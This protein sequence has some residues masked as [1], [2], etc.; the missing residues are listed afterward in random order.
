MVRG[1]IEGRVNAIFCVP[2]R[3]FLSFFCAIESRCETSEEKKSPLILLFSARSAQSVEWDRRLFPPFLFFLSFFPSFVSQEEEEE[4]RNVSVGEE[5]K[6][7][8]QEKE[9]EWI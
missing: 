9:T 8:S 6:K 2:G 5:S 1:W 7:V 4:H 3:P